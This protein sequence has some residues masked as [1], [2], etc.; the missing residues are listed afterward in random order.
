MD[1]GK[2]QLIR[3]GLPL[4]GVKFS[5]S[6][7]RALPSATIGCAFSAPN[8]RGFD[9]L[10]FRSHPRERA[11]TKNAFFS[12]NAFFLVHEKSSK[13]PTKSRYFERRKISFTLSFTFVHA[14]KP[15]TRDFVN[16]GRVVLSSLP[17]RDILFDTFPD[18]PCLATIRSSLCDCID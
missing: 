7:P 2:V 11:K 3:F 10:S 5:C 17:G 15:H 14:C 9:R 1:V 12:Q 13:N 4:Q 18:T 16:E 6:I 8:H